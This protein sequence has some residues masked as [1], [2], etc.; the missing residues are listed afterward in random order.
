MYF[1]YHYFKKSN[2][3]I[4]FPVLRQ[5]NDIMEPNLFLNVIKEPKKGLLEIKLLILIIT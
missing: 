1:I 2:L 4:F 5:I 3:C